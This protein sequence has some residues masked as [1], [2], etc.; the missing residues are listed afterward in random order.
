MCTKSSKDSE[1]PCEVEASLLV[2][3]IA[4]P[5]LVGDSVKAA[6]LRAARRLGWKPSRTKEIWYGRARR[7]E[8]REMD[9]L[10][11]LVAKGAARY[12]AIARAMERTDSALYREDIA[13]LV[14]MARRLRGEDL[15]RN[16]TRKPE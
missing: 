1:M 16:R 11:E 8:A 9:A 12:E 7:I 13:A 4:E 10:R 2:K 3:R 15:P 5:R 14:H 6:I